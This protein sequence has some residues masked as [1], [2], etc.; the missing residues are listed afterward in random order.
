MRKIFL[1]SHGDSCV[2]MKN[3]LEMILG[4]Q[5]NVLTLSLL[6]SVSAIDFYNQLKSLIDQENSDNDE[7]LIMADLK[8]GTPANTAFLLMKEYSN[9]KLITGFH[10]A[11]VIQACLTNEEPQQLIQETNNMIQE[12]NNEVK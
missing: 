9:I 8:G 6:S 12:I 1:I 3:S 2:G 7:I 11:L 5:S 10:L 4:E